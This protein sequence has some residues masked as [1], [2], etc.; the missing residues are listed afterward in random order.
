MRFLDERAA[1]KPRAVDCPWRKRRRVEAIGDDDA[2]RG[3]DAEQ[4]DRSID[5]AWRLNDEARAVPGP[6]PHP[7]G[8]RTGVG[9][10]SRR[11]VV[12][13]LEQHQLGAV[14]VADNRD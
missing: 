14:Q 13:L 2:V 1:P 4:G 8:P 7:P 6:A 3:L 10:V 12:D 5:V 11:P 9:P